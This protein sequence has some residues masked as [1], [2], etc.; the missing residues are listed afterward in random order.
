MNTEEPRLN[1]VVTIEVGTSV[2]IIPEGK[3]SNGVVNTEL[4]LRLSWNSKRHWEPATLSVLMDVVKIIDPWK[5]W[6]S[7]DW[8]FSEHKRSMPS[9]KHRFKIENCPQFVIDTLKM[10]LENDG[11]VLPNMSRATT[12]NLVKTTLGTFHELNRNLCETSVQIVNHLCAR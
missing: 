7:Q 3:I 2:A 4:P 1:C 6:F 5:N 9:N 12:E 10:E 8:Q 11:S